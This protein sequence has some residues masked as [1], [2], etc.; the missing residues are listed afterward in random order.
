MQP[1]LQ[2]AIDLFNDDVMDR[3]D[4]RAWSE[5]EQLR[6][7]ALRNSKRNVTPWEKLHDNWKCVWFSK[8]VEQMAAQRDPVA[9]LVQLLGNR[10]LARAAPEVAS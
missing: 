7:H 3:F 9:M 10:E 8:A 5:A 2:A 4:K 6:K 1:E